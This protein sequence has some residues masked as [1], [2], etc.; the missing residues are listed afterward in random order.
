MQGESAVDEQGDGL[1][2]FEA[3]V[4]ILVYPVEN[5]Q[6]LSQL[7]EVVDLGGGYGADHASI[8]VQQRPAGLGDVALT[9][10]GYVFEE[11]EHRDGIEGLAG[12]QVIGRTSADEAELT[13]V[14][15]KGITIDTD[16]GADPVLEDAEQGTIGAAA[17]VEHVGAPREVPPR[18]PDAPVLEY[19]V[20][21]F[22]VGAG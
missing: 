6:A 22:H 14:V 1:G 18:D 3:V 20:A 15:R 2:R 4:L 8:G 11:G 21:L 9:V 5:A 10:R 17:D 13:V 19:H 12:R 7:D 16:A